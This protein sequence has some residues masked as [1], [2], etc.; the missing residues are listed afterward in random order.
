MAKPGTRTRRWRDSAG[1][2]VGSCV[3]RAS[4]VGRH[5]AAP[6][7]TVSP[8]PVQIRIRVDPGEQYVNPDPEIGAAPIDLSRWAEPIGRWRKGRDRVPKSDL[9]TFRPPPLR[10]YT[11]GG[12]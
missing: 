12:C 9:L 8:S 6:V 3:P 5:E 4:S 11:P 1:P 7:L 2:P 10:S